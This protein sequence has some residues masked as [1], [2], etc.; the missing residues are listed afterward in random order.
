M[1]NGEV[2]ASSGDGPKLIH[3]N[4]KLS[5]GEAFVEILFPDKKSGNAGL[6]LRVD[7]PA[8]GA[9]HFT[10]YEIALYPDTGT[11]LLGR[12]RQNWEPITT[13]PCPVPINEW[14]TLQVQLKGRSITVTVNGQVRLQHE[15]NQHPL[16]E[17]QIG[18]RTWQREAS[19]RNLRVT[20]GDRRG[21]RNVASRQAWK[22]SG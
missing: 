19:F 8:V 21:Q 6:I 16:V 20:S 17:G 15:D 5:D 4:T 7:R 10:G 13:V 11:L 12:H 1:Q 3:Q 9:D 2:V 22:L 18:L 14:I